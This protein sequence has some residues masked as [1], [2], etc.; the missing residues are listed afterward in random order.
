MLRRNQAP[1]SASTIPNRNGMRQPQALRVSA[2][3][4]EVSNAPVPDPS[5]RLNAMD[6][7]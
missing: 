5:T 1:T 7:C 4:M 6:A 2:L 3:M